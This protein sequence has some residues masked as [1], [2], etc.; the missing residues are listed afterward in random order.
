MLAKVLRPLAAVFF[1]GAVACGG[2]TS[3]TRQTN[4]PR[5]GAQKVDPA[6]AA[7]V[8]GRV[9]FQ[10]TPPENPV[11]TLSG[12][13]ACT[14]EHPGGYVFENYAVKDGGLDNVFIY[15]KDGLGNYHFD[16]P[17]QPVLLD[18]KGCRY[19]PHVLGV[20]VGQPIQIT[21]SDDTMHNVHAVPDVN[22]EV[23][24][25]QH[26]KGMQN[27]QVFTAAE[28]MVPVR[29]DLH[30]WMQAFVG[31]VE[32]PFYAVTTNGGRFELKGLPP[33]TYTIEAWHEKSGTQTQ[34]VAVG[35][36]ETKDLNFTF[37]ATGPGN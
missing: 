22:G 17:S 33:G 19:T 25:G 9:V 5:E 4:T 1:V 11:R 36:K 15:V 23:N 35:A 10:G 24:F 21:N 26:K 32:H 27:M 37:T 3:D 18:Q 6:T 20:R 30:G 2:G 16:I 14:R 29:C 34:Q 7:V 28:V 13:P 8:T 31:V 12:D